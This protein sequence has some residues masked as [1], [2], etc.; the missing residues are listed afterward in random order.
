MDAQLEKTLAELVMIPSESMKR[1]ACRAIIEYAL[2]RL[3]PLGMHITAEL[4][5]QHPWMIATTQP[6]KSPKILLVAHLDVVPANTPAQYELHKTDTR[7]YGRGV[8]DMKYAAAG[9]IEF[10]AAYADR[11]AELDFGILFTTDEEVGG[12]QGVR[13]ILRQGWR[14]ELAFIPDFSDNWHIE[15]K[16]KGFTCTKLTASGKSTHGS[17]P[18]EGDNAIQKLIPVL[19]E[20]QAMYPF[21]DKYGST[22]SIN[23]VSGGEAMNQVPDEASAWL[24]FRSFDMSEIEEFLQSIARISAEYD[25]KSEELASGRPLILDKQNHLVQRYAATLSQLGI[26]PTYQK[27]FGGTDG[28]WFAEFD[29]PCIVTGP[30]G[31][32][33]HGE[34]EWI[35]RL[36][37][38]RLYSIVEHYILNNAHVKKS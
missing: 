30:H 36:D 17:R 35:E 37:L 25:L 31:G 24:D 7:Y 16:A 9:F 34:Q 2:E 5:V 8:W 4:D 33:S 23:M 38:Q 13:E 19:H 1:A 20:L 22:L 12:F 15:E 21:G 6:T 14:T 27:S 18:W 29:I 32:D 28:R 10:A 26:K 11:L 3:Q